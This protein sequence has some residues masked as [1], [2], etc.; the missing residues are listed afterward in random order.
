MCFV[1][2]IGIA[3]PLKREAYFVMEGLKKMGISP[4]VLTRVKFACNHSHTP[5]LYLTV[6]YMRVL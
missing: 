5:F 6:T 1:G 2:L 4:V 3:G